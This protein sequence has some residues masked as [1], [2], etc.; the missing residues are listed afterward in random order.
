MRYST[1]RGDNVKNLK[2]WNVFGAYEPESL[3]SDFVEYYSD[4]RHGRSALAAT[5]QLLKT[6]KVVRHVAFS[7]EDEHMPWWYEG[8]IVLLDNMHVLFG[9]R[10]ARYDKY[11]NEVP[12]DKSLVILMPGVDSAALKPSDYEVLIAALDWMAGGANEC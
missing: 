3:A 1:F 9:K 11:G 5:E 2:F 4:P 7:T 6:G 12:F 10:A 8:E